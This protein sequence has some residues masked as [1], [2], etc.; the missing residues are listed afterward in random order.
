MLT[1]SAC[2]L[3]Q[4][5]TAQLACMT[6]CSCSAVT[7]LLEFSIVDTSGVRRAARVR[8]TRA[9]TRLASPFMV[10]QSLEN[11]QLVKYECDMPEQ[12]HAGEI[13]L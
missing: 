9:H 5:V 8:C 13:T 11:I 12:F 10:I 3:S 6:S 2:A 4:A 1:G 7:D